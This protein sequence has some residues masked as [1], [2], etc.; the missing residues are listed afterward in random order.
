MQALTMRV[1]YCFFVNRRI[2]AIFSFAVSILASLLSNSLYAQDYPAKP[3]RI[4]VPSAIGG[5]PDLIAR[6]IAPRLSQGL[7]QQIIIEN[8]P[9]AGGAPAMASVAKSTG[10]GYTLMFATPGALIIAAKLMANA[11]Y[12]PVKSFAPVSL[13]IT[14]PFLLVANS[15]VSANSL[16][17]LIDLARLKP[18]TL[19]YGTSNGTLPHLSGYVFMAAT[20]VSI[21]PVTYKSISQAYLDLTAG[22]IQLMFEQVALFEQGIRSG[23]I[24]ALA[25]ASS[26]RHPKLPDVPTANEA[27]LPGFEVLSWAG[28][29]APKDTP[30][31]IIKRLNF[32][33]VSTLRSKEVQESLLNLGIDPIGSTPEQFAKFINIETEKWTSA[34]NASGAKAD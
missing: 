5:S 2:R 4:I 13:L 27:G 18:G 7:G 1:Q 23:K 25:V 20:G 11:G 26:K 8:R 24:K 31:E 9:G 3:I 6:I 16:K 12:D 22:T 19:N 17:D 21:T 33:I 29:L 34:I 32:E 10:D 15:E 28:L 30:T 14:A